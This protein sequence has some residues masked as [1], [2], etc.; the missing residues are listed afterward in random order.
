MTQPNFKVTSKNTGANSAQII[1]EP[2]PQ[3]FGHTLG[4]SLRRI[5]LTSLEGG[6]ATSVKIEGVNHQFSTIDG[7]QEDVLDFILN[8]KSVNFLVDSDEPKTVRLNASGAKE[9]T[10]GDLELPTGV[11]ISEP[12]KVLATL[13]SPKAKLNATITVAKGVGYIPAEEHATDEIGVIPLDSSFSPV[14]SASYT[15]ESTRV[16]RDTNFDKIRLNVTTNGT[17]DPMTVFKQAAQI[18][19]NY[20]NHINSD[21]AYKIEVKSKP[22]LERPGFVDD[23]ELPTRVINALKKSDITKLSDLAQLS[24]EDLKKVKNLGE[25]SALQVVEKAREKDIIIA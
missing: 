7:L 8:L 3:N 1:I 4:N 2:L 24:L 11:E 19:T 25:K 18:A 16:G 10:V 9:V 17:V 20:F 14:I 22:T 23:L 13:T 21:E 15:V 12:K 5:L 6:A